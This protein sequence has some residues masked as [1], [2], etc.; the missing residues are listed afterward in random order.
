M[1]SLVVFLFD[2][3]AASAADAAAVALTARWMSKN[4]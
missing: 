3:A 2:A 4:A 1:R